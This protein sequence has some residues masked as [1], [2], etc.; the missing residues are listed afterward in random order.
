MDYRILTT[1]EE[2]DPLPDLQTA[3]WHHDP[4]ES[5]PVHMFLPVVHNGGVVIGAFDDRK[6]VGF[7]FGLPLRHAGRFI[8]WSHMAAVLPDYQDRGI[9]FDLKQAQRTWALDNG[10]DT[11]GWTYDPLQRGNAN[12]NLHRLGAA[13]H[14]YLVNYY[15]TLFDGINAGLPSDRLEV[16]WRLDDSH[17]R[18]LA[19]ETH[20]EAVHPAPVLESFV[21]RADAAG[22]PLIDTSPLASSQPCY[23][24]IPKDLQRLKRDNL[25]AARIWRLALRSSLVDAFAGGFAAVDFITVGERCCYVLEKDV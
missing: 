21:L 25:D 6:L 3:V 7:C 22:L 16:L 20:T 14:T 2:L 10:Y 1:P 18:L 15:G 19:R 17:V 11:I 23:V 4:V 9:G 24:E 5:V 8:L 12:F 13:A